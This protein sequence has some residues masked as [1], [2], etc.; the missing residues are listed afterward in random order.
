MIIHISGQTDGVDF[1]EREREAARLAAEIERGLSSEHTMRDAQMDEEDLFRSHYRSLSLSLYL[2]PLALTAVLGT[3]VLLI[4]TPSSARRSSTRHHRLLTTTT[5]TTTVAAAAKMC[6]ITTL[7]HPEA[8]VLLPAVP[9]T[10]L[11]HPDWR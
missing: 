8:A 6:G 10:L 3:T 4:A 5:T 1:H 9:S 7:A 2:S 11:P